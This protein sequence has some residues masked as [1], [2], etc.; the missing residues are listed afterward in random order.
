MDNYN[1]IK[2]D[3]KVTILLKSNS[4]NEGF[5]RVSVSAFVSQLDPTISE[6]ED[7]KTAV[8]EAVTNSII[9]GY[10]DTDSSSENIVT[11][12]CGYIKRKVHI[13]IEDEGKGIFDIEKAREA[14]YTSKSDMDRSGMGFTVMESFMDSVEVIS[15]I[16][17]GTKVIMTKELSL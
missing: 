1:T 14:L 11:I 6:I 13:E 12:R 9:H 8:S 7:I 16:G 5:A 3:N 2:Y 4:I 15:A 17:K 10:E